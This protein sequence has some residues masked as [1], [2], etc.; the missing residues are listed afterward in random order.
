VEF[1][2]PLRQVHTSGDVPLARGFEVMIELAPEGPG[3]RMTRTLR[4]IPALGPIG[5]LFRQLM[6]GRVERDTRKTVENLVD[7]VRR[8]QGGERRRLKVASSLRRGR[9]SS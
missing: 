2:P 6:R 4:G 5:L 1:A 8:D 3:T 7:L 9:T